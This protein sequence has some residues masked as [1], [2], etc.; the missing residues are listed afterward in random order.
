MVAAGQGRFS[1]T[2]WLLGAADTLWERTGKRLGGTAAIEGLHQRAEG[3]ARDGLGGKRYERLFRDGAGQG[4]GEIVGL[5]TGDAD[6]L[7]PVSRGQLTRREREVA[8]LVGESLTSAQI[9]RRLV[10]SRRTVDTHIAS[11]Y[12]KLGVSS[13]VQ[14]VTWLGAQSARTPGTDPG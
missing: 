13:R 7:P 3:T 11:I 5:A 6:R 8:A 12:A 4:L 10:I 14:L 2:A 9:A 1:R